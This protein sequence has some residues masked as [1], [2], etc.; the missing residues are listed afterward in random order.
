MTYQKKTENPVE[1]VLRTRYGEGKIALKNFRNKCF[2]AVESQKTNRGALEN[3]GNMLEKE[4]PGFKDHY[5]IHNWKQKSKN[6]DGTYGEA[7]LSKTYESALNVYVKSI[8]TSV[9]NH[10]RKSN[11]KLNLKLEEQLNLEPFVNSQPKVSV[12]EFGEMSPTVS[13]IIALA[14]KGVKSV[15]TPD[16]WEVQF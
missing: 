2:K 16:G 6:K 10:G 5:P 15:K 11:Q 8:T 13:G 9:K 12:K 1:F 3:I 4:Y 7:V 14:D